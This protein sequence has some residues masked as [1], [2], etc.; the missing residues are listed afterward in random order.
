MRR[1]V[2]IAAIVALAGCNSEPEIEATNASVEEVANQV[3][4]ASGKDQFIRPGR[5]V[6]TV[7]IEDVSAPGMPAQAAQQLKGM[8]GEGQ[9]FET[10]LTEEQ[11]QRPREDF[12]AGANRQCRYD[13]FTMGDGKI[14]AQ[15][16]CAQGGASQVMKM[17]GTYSPSSYEIRM[18]SSLEDAE[19]PGAGMAMRMRVNAERAGECTGKQT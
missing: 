15:M 2:L 13:H 19:G 12:F 5:W 8:M 6:S 10:C 1:A 4:E 3:R 14:D 18:T 16:R 17:S 7:T 11:A 9:R